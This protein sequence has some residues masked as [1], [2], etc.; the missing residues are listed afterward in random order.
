MVS[1]SIVC[2]FTFVKSK[3]KNAECGRALRPL[4]FEKDFSALFLWLREKN[5]KVSFIDLDR[6]LNEDRLY[7]A[8]GVHP[9]DAGNARMEGRLREWVKARSLRP[10]DSE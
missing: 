4:C 5:E 7:A 6:V 1:N 3:I 8:N 2:M 10:V 9:N